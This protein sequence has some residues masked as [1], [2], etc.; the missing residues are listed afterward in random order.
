[1][2]TRALERVGA[3]AAVVLLVVVSGCS[4]DSDADEAKEQDLA[5]QLVSALHQEGLAPRLTVDVAASMYGTDASGV[6]DV[7]DDGL[8][9]AEKNVI[10][11]NPAHGR[12][13]TITDDAVAYGT[14]VVKTYCPD[15]LP[16]YQDAVADLDPYEKSDS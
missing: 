11:G 2:A 16:E 14:V 6:C 12:R 13:K 7:F 9:T 4:S 5:Q 15:V 10:L 3:L 1:M 8:S